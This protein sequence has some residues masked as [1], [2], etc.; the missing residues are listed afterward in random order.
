MLRLEHLV[1]VSVSLAVLNRI[2]SGAVK[3]AVENQSALLS[4]VFQIGELDSV[5]ESVHDLDFALF[6]S[7]A[8]QLRELVLELV[9]NLLALRDLV[10][11]KATDDHISGENGCD[12][13]AQSE[14]G[15]IG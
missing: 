10:G 2:N 7:K 8:L 11:L 1:T 3:G 13:Q 9:V 5:V 12:H 15:Q 6:D 14:D 4:V